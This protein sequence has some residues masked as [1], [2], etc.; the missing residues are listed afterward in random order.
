[1]GELVRLCLV[2]NIELL[3]FV[4]EYKPLVL[5]LLVLGLVLAALVLLLL[6]LVFGSPVLEPD[7]DL[8]EKNEAM[9]KLW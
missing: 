8:R 4:L 2:L 3:L 9:S 7:F 1:M 5:A 6:P